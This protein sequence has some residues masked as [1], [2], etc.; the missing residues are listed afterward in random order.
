[1]FVIRRIEECCCAQ[2]KTLD[3]WLRLRFVAE[4]ILVAVNGD[5]NLP[6]ISDQLSS[7][8]TTTEN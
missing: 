5:C 1:M 3:K 8:I 7:G 2:V 6:V 4:L